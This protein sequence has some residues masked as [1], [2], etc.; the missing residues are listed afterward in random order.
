MNIDQVIRII[1]TKGP[2]LPVQIAK[3]TGSN[4]MLAGAM[5]SSLVSEKKIMIS[6]TKIG[7]SPVY[8]LKEQQ[9]RLQELYKYLNEKDKKTFDLLKSSKVLRDS[10]QDPLTRVSLR[11]IKDFAIPLNVTLGEKTELFWKW[12]LANDEE[13]KNII[14][15][16]LKVEEERPK[17]IAEKVPVKEVQ[18]T[19]KAVEPQTKLEKKEE[20]PKK[21]E[22]EAIKEDFTENKP[23]LKGSDSFVDKI[24]KFLKEKDILIKDIQVKKK[25]SEIDLILSVPS[26]V[27]SLEYYCRAKNK[28]RVNDADLSAAYVQGQIKKLPVMLLTPGSLTKKAEQLLEKEVKIN[29]VKLE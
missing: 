12:Y 7:G 23:E 9:H 6:S 21:T 29:F 5:L 25:N 17:E 16:I 24:I 11:A 15:D 2:I 18:E 22:K 1:A 8:Y 4:T 27:G 26:M 14:K 20:E 10:E 19:K 3:E 13:V 28:S